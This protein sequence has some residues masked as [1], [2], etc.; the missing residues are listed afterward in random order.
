MNLK[1]IVDDMVAVNAE[2]RTNVEA[3]ID[4]IDNLPFRSEW[5]DI[6]NNCKNISTKLQHLL[7]DLEKK[8][9]QLLNGISFSNAGDL[10]AALQYQDKI[11]QWL[12]TRPAPDT[13]LARQELKATISKL[14]TLRDQVVHLESSIATYLLHA[15]PR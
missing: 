4:Y 15:T 9:E 5:A 6:T 12:S 3:L 10:R 1:P 11:Y 7:S 2:K 8:Q 14:K 13:D